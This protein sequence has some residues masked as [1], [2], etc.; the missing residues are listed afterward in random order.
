MHIGFFLFKPSGPFSYFKLL[1]SQI[2]IIIVDWANVFFNIKTTTTTKLLLSFSSASAKHWKRCDVFPT[3]KE[4][5]Y[6]TSVGWYLNWRV[7]NKRVYVC[8]VHV[9]FSPLKFIHLYQL[10][11]CLIPF[12]LFRHGAQRHFS[13]SR[14]ILYYWPMQYVS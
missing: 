1:E 4:T 5:L 9:I 12:L 10:R 2:N 13:M 3:K 14:A 11:K 7:Q 8:L 6:I